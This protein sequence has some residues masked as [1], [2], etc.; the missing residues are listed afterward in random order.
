M[1]YLRQLP[2]KLIVSMLILA[3]RSA[4]VPPA[5]MEHEI[6]SL[7]FKLTCE[8]VIAAASL[9]YFLILVLQIV[10]HFFL[11]YTEESDGWPPAPFCQRCATCRMIASTTHTPWYGLYICVELTP[12]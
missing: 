11:W 9:R 12:L 8:L 4:M 1:M 10:D 6:T 2:T 5:C 3:I 7:V